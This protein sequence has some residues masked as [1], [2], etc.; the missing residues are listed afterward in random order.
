MNINAKSLWYMCIKLPRL[1]VYVKSKRMTQ[2]NKDVILNYLV[3]EWLL[4]MQ[5]DII[6]IQAITEEESDV[7]KGSVLKTKYMIS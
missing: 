4:L 6:N 2:E 5:K 7:N 3:Q 1:K